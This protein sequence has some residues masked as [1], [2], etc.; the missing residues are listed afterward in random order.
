MT[1]NAPK[2]GTSLETTCG[3]QFKTTVGVSL[4]TMYRC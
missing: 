3:C 1:I 2:I 4:E